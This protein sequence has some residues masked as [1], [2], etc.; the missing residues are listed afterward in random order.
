MAGR[1]LIIL[2]TVRVLKDAERFVVFGLQKNVS[3]G[4]IIFT[5]IIVGSQGL[6][7]VLCPLEDDNPL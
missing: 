1:S 2:P 5:G 7:K 6:G 4:H 3:S